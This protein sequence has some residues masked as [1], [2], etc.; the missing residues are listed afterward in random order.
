MKGWPSTKITKLR[1]GRGRIWIQMWHKIL[2]HVFSSLIS[3]RSTGSEEVRRKIWH[4]LFFYRPSP[5]EV[6]LMF[7]LSEVRYPDVRKRWTYVLK[8][9]NTQ[10]VRH[11]PS[12]ACGVP[13]KDSCKPCNYSW[14][15]FPFILNAFIHKQQTFKRHHKFHH[16]DL[17][18]QGSKMQILR[19]LAIIQWAIM[20]RDNH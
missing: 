2:P 10:R 7:P 12:P 20:L 17:T 1:S 3:I 19:G 6:F 8:E 14:P 13:W 5:N 4:G 16:P 9:N 15:T 11:C 18:F